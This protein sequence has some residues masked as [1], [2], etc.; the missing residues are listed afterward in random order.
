MGEIQRREFIA[1][2]IL[3]T[4]SSLVWLEGGEHKRK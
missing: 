1:G 2:S 4:G 3:R